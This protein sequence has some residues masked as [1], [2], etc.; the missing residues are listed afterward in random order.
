M[1]YKADN[2]L[3]MGPE[4]LFPGC[5][6]NPTLEA[7][8]FFAQDGGHVWCSLDPQEIPKAD[9]VVIPGGVPDVNPALYGEDDLESHNL[10]PEM[11]RQQMEMI[12]RAFALHKPMLGIC[13][14]MQLVN[15][16]LGGTLIQNLSTSDVHRFDPQKKLFHNVYNVPRSW[17]F[18]TY[19]KEMKIN[20]GHHQALKKLPE[21]IRVTQLWCSQ[22]EAAEEYVKRANAGE[23][24]EGTHDC[25][26]EAVE[27]TAYPYIG[28]QWH[29]ELGENMSC[30]HLD[31]A[32]IRQYI[33]TLQEQ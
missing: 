16:F 26:I 17:F 32:K 22:P 8:A 19:G 20:T 4:E 10:T 29:P 5:P 33:Y 25:V 18:Q 14:G 27:H 24:R 9:L 12:E 2:V 30:K 3:I 1:E 7:Q 6:I 23:L 13:R 28:L 21:K 15:V 11:D 31:L